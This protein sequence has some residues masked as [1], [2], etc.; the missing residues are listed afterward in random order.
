MLAALLRYAVQREVQVKVGKGI[1]TVD[2]KFEG[3]RAAGEHI[4]ARLKSDRTLS[5]KD[6]AAYMSVA[7]RAVMTYS[8]AAA[9][10][11]LVLDECPLCKKRGDTVLHRIWLCQH[12]DAVRA[13]EAVVPRWLLQEF[14]RATNREKDEF[15]VSG[16]IPHPAD[17]WPAPAGEAN[18]VYEWA[19]PNPPQQRMIMTPRGGRL[20]GASSM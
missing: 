16:I 6:R 19:G 7:C 11:Y 20:W 9:M 2:S 15:W 14:D 12:P 3:R 13:R 8:R 1:A 5:A 10:G 18:A 4:A 17:V